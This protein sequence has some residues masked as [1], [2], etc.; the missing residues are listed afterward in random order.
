MNNGKFKYIAELVCNFKQEAAGKIA[1]NRLAKIKKTFGFY[2]KRFEWTDFGS[3]A[4][5]NLML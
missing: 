2:C 1:N 3:P 4:V 5:I